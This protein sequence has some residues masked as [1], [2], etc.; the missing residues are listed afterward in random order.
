MHEPLRHEKAVYAVAYSPDGQTVLTGSE[1][2]TARLWDAATHRPLAVTLMHQGTVYAVAFRP[3]DG[4]MI[5]TGSDDR[6]ARLWQTSTGDPVGKPLLHPARVLAVAF[7]PDGRIIATGCGDG[8]A[9]LWDTATGHPIGR[10]LL[11]RGPVRAVAFGPSPRD[12]APEAERWILVTG[13]ED[14][15]A[16]VWEIPPPLADSPERI[17]LSLQVASGMVLDTQAVAD[18]LTPAAWRQ[19]R[20]E[21]NTAHDGRSPEAVR[22]QSA[23]NGSPTRQISHQNGPASASQVSSANRAIPARSYRS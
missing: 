4:Q 2:M 11:H 6:T 12:S 1:D 5:L 8:A 20:R 10:P 17:M 23:I 7:S 18:S 16:R 15:T 19:L 22:R 21:L 3:P 9:R 14:M 13:S